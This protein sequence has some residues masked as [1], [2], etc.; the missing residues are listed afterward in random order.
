MI[1]KIHLRA[2]VSAMVLAAFSMAC[3]ATPRAESRIVRRVEGKKT[4]LLIGIEQYDRPELSRVNFAIRDVQ[5]T[6]K[7]LTALGFDARTLTSDEKS[8]YS[9][10]HP[11]KA[12]ILKQLSQIASETGPDDI[13]LFYYA[14]HEITKG[15]REF[16]HNAQYRRFVCDEP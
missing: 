1:H 13:L 14:G 12:T 9:P 8:S 2:C 4:A 6:A 16:P 11:S 3:F 10:A 7:R 5:D 15:G